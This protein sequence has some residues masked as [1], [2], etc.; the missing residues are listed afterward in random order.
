MFALSCAADVFERVGDA[1]TAAVLATSS[2]AVPIGPETAAVEGMAGQA[3]LS[4]EATVVFA[5]DEIDRA[6]DA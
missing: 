3:P 4:L 2:A 6:L 5:L 1:H